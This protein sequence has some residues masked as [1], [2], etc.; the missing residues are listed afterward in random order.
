MLL[1]LKLL[2]ARSMQT[3]IHRFASN[4]HAAAFFAVETSTVCQAQT[5][6]DL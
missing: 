6:T 3:V 1:K 5:F 4:D 2:Q